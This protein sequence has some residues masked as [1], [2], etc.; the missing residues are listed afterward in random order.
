MIEFWTGLWGALLLVALLVFLGL[1]AVVS[2]L[3][4]K[5]AKALFQ[6]LRDRHSSQ[7][8]DS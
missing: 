7:D 5:D 4:F 8:R 3:G 2:I 1:S 6:G